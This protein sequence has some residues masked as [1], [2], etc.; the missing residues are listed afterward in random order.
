DYMLGTVLKI[1]NRGTGVKT[2]QHA[3]QLKGYWTNA[4]GAFGTH[5][6]RT[7]KRFQADQGLSQSGTTTDLTWQRLGTKIVSGI[8][9]I[10]AMIDG[11]YQESVD[12]PVI[13]LPSGYDGGRYGLFARGNTHADF[14]Y[15]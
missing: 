13:D 1:G 9:N 14:E 5:T 11:V 6:E 12:I 3:L 15:L 10:T 4:D 2:L 7:L 8:L